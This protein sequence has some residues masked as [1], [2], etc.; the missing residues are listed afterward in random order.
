MIGVGAHQVEHG[1]GVRELTVTV[2]P[3]SDV[4][5]PGCRTAAFAGVGQVAGSD[6]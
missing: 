5:W 4:A 2:T 1:E 6:L 3:G